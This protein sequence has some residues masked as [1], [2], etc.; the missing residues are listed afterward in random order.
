MNFRDLTLSEKCGH[1][2]PRTVWFHSYKVPRGVRSIE[3]EEMGGQG[4]GLG[5][6][7]LM[8]TDFQFG[9]MRKSRR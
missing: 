4:Q 8:G 9:R 7:C 2:K 6:E 3:T 5:S 1:K